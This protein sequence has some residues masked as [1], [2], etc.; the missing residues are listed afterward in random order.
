MRPVGRCAFSGLLA[1][2]HMPQYAFTR[3][4]SQEQENPL[5]I[6]LNAAH[7]NSMRLLYA[8]KIAPALKS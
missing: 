7:S 3:A 1:E 8:A 5:L 6:R 4:A 2:G